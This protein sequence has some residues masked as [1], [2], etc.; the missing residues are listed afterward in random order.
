ML[1]D[2]K[3]ETLG[4]KEAEGWDWD[5]LADLINGP[6]RNPARLRE[7]LKSEFVKSILSFVLPSKKRLEALKR[8][9]EAVG[10]IQVVCE[11]VGLLI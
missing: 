8:E 10:Y 9:P 4:Y 5:K 3:V 1:Q 2:C 11:L 6:L 7:V